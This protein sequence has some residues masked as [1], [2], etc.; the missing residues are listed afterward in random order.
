[1]ISHHKL[2]LFRNGTLLALMVAFGVFFVA[3][4]S[5]AEESASWPRPL[6]N[7]ILAGVKCAD[8]NLNADVP[9][10]IGEGGKTYDYKAAIDCTPC[11]LVR[12]GVNV[13]NLFV[14]FSGLLLLLIFIYAGVLMMVSYANPGYLK[15]AKEA[16]KYGLIGL[17]LIFGA[18]TFVNFL[19]SALYGGVGD[20]SAVNAVISEMTGQESWGVCKE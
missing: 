13:S 15:Q 17:V 9:V 7:S 6:T 8:P 19:L 3:G 10:P 18:Y 1:M 12:V 20:S 5:R 14:S 16:I 4:V 2:N 11:D